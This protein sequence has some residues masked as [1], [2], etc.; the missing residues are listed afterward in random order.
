MSLAQSDFE[1]GLADNGIYHVQHAVVGHLLT[2]RDCQ[3]SA[4]SLLRMVVTV[5]AVYVGNA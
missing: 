1:G 3:I 4:N 2:Q 5:F